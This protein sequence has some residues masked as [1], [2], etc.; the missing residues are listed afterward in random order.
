MDLQAELDSIY[1]AL[2]EK[3][4][5]I[6]HSMHFQSRSSLEKVIQQLYVLSIECEE[7]PYAHALQIASFNTQA[8]CT[9]V[10]ALYS[11]LLLDMSYRLSMADIVRLCMQKRFI[12]YVYELSG[13]GSAKHVLT[14]LNQRAKEQ[15]A[16]HVRDNAALIRSI[17]LSN[18]NEIEAES[19]VEL[20]L[21]VSEMGA[22]LALG[23]LLDR[24]PIT[25]QGEANRKF[26]LEEY[27]P[28]PQLRPLE[29]YRGAVANV[30]MLCSYSTSEHKHGIKRHLNEWFKRTLH[31][32]HVK[33]PS[34]TQRPAA[35]GKK[36]I[37]IA[38]ES[39]NSLHAMYRWY[40]PIIKK[41]REEFRLVLLALP[42][43]VDE[44]SKQLFDAYVPIP[45]SELDL[46]DVLN[47]CQP[48]IVYFPSIGMRAWS[49]ALANVRWAPLQVMSLG[50]PATS[51]IDTIDAVF[52]DRR[53]Y[54][55]PDVFSENL[56]VLD[57]EVGSLIEAHKR[58]KL[59]EPSVL[60]DDV[61]KIAVPCHAMK[62]NLPFMMALKEIEQRAEKPVQFTFFP[63]EFGLGKLSATRRL[64]SYFPTATVAPRMSYEAYL[65]LIAG[66]HFALSPFPFGNASSTMDC[67]VLGLPILALN[68]PEPHSRSDY[69]VMAAFDLAQFFVAEQVQ[70]YIGA[71]VELINKPDLLL[72]MKKLVASRHILDRHYSDHNDYTDEFC[73]ALA[74]A[75]SNRDTLTAQPGHAYDAQGRWA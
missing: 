71:A 44:H 32:K 56:L 58:L 75:Y 72:E 27:N 15:P 52:M 37:A 69:N 10:A 49:I 67:L 59:P 20:T 3:L 7:K 8:L 22:L 19:L 73:R 28:Y 31:S 51:Q 61:I 47:S 34:L 9:R 2:D 55:G 54:G 40:A 46:Q 50:H 39:F 57:A 42:A 29:A 26:L 36:T 11:Q 66:H 14:L 25:L 38:A 64:T 35:P 70:E 68:G 63:N 45:G 23:L 65:E 33:A 1:N 53:T 18:I 16:K 48:D 30:W 13:F 17:L 21:D 6:E 4:R 60:S 5:A 62:I 43:D 74:W 41:L 12:G 24:M